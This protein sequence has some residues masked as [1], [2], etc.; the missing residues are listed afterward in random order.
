MGNRLTRTTTTDAA[1]VETLYTY[2][3]NDRLLTEQATETVARGPFLDDG[4]RYAAVPRPSPHARYWLVAVFTL[5]CAALL[6][7]L[8]LL[9]KRGRKIGR[10]ARRRRTFTRT[11]ALFLT[12]TM[13]IGPDNVEAIHVE[14]QLY[15]A[16]AVAAQGQPEPPTTTFTYGYDNNGNTLSRT[17]GVSANTY[18][19]D[20]Q[21]RLSAAEIQLGD[22]PGPVSYTYDADGIRNSKTAG[23]ITTSYLTDKNRPFAQV[24]VEDDDADQVSYDYGDDLLSMKRTTGTSYYHYDGMMS[25]R[26]LTDAAAVATDTYAYDAFGNLLAST[27]ATANAYRYTGEQF[28]GNVGNYDLRARYYDQAVG[29][30]TTTDPFGGGVSDPVSLH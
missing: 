13:L 26:A 4:T 30:F 11:V 14:A 27:G 19:Y 18:A 1:L 28:D 2:D 17:D 3:D 9:R 21:N 24:L 8:G 22:L 20:F 10:A 25:A 6:V 16:L 12:P 15:G 23:G 5:T 29:R 7:P